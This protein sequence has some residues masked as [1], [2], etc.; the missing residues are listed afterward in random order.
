VVLLAVEVVLV[1]KVNMELVVR[2]ETEETE[3]MGVLVETVV[4]V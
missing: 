1:E 2:V 3:I 4:L